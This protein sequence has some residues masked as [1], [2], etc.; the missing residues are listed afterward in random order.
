MPHGHS[1][2]IER[3]HA[4]ADDLARAI[5]DIDK[6]LEQLRLANQPI[7][8]DAYRARQILGEAHAR[9]SERVGP[10]IRI[11][12]NPRAARIDLVARSDRS[13]RN[14]VERYEALPGFPYP[15]S[16]AQDLTGRLT[17]MP[18]ADLRFRKSIC[19]SHAYEGTTTAYD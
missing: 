2:S 10:R 5:A 11:P 18:R 14:P 9:C 17:P 4:P 7:P 15:P 3:K 6:R 19:G 1:R 16:E 12:P 8:F 13:R